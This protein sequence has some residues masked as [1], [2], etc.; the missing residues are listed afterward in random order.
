MNQIRPVEPQDL[1]PILHLIQLVPEAPAWS[2]EDFRRLVATPSLEIPDAAL[3]RTA[4][5]AESNALVLGMA[6][7][8]CLGTGDSIQPECELESIVVDPNARRTGVGR[9]LLMT[10]MQW[11][12]QQ[13]ASV[14]RL[15]VRIGNVPA[16][17]L[18]ER[19]GFQ[20]TGRRPR[21]YS[22]PEEDALL[23]EYRWP[24]RLNL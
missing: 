5:V 22:Y 18:Y 7:V 15:E 24:A 21:Y 2:V 17:S 19:A 16:I 1:A 10:V 6:V 13:D 3:T 20:Q 12:E 23:M 14:L 9:Q 11:C 8:Q 4:W